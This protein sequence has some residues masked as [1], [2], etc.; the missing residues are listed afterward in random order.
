MM[1]E[2]ALKSLEY[3]KFKVKQAQGNFSAS[4]HLFESEI[5]RLGE[6]QF[7]KEV[8]EA[9]KKAQQCDYK[10]LAPV[11]AASVCIP[12]GY[13]KD[14]TMHVIILSLFKAAIQLRYEK[15]VLE[16]ANVFFSNDDDP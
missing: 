11:F 1:K 6:Y 2:K 8:C 5:D 3:Q 10:E 16:S 14:S 4:K 12:K 15:N 13:L 9:L 7:K